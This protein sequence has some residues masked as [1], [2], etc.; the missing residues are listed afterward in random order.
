MRWPCL[1]RSA[2]QRTFQRACV[3][4]PANA[5]AGG[6]PS[7]LRP[8]S[9]RLRSSPLRVQG[10]WGRSLAAGAGTDLPDVCTAPRRP[11]AGD[12]SFLSVRTRRLSPSPSSQ[13]LARGV[14][15]VK[16]LLVTGV[17]DGERL[18]GLLCWASDGRGGGAQLGVLRGPGGLSPK[19]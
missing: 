7:W 17:R 6:R 14:S 13:R 9:R 5:H 10:P 8:S 19:G 12:C 1:V 15:G 16:K 3:R 4:E 11:G 18:E 2:S